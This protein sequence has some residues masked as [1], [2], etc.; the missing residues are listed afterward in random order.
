MLKQYLDE[1]VVGQDRAKKTL[2]VAV[3]NH[4]QRVQELR[5]R[6]DELA[7]QLA[8]RMRRKAGDSSSVTG[9]FHFSSL[10]VSVPFPLC[11]RT[12][13]S[14]LCIHRELYHRTTNV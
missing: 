8:K 13:I 2:C 4:Y 5:R 1:Y 14:W 3:Y 10:F 7:E 9:I 12:D 11:T 6:E